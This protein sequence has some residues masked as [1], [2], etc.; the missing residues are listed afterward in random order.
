M[1]NNSDLDSR[2]LEEVFPEL[3][4][5]THPLGNRVLVQLRKVRSKSKGGVIIVEETKQAERYNEMVCRVVELGPLAYKNVDDLSDWKEGPWCLPGDFVRVAK[6]GGDRWSVPYGV[7]DDKDWVHFIVV[8]D[9]EI[10]A[11]IDSFEA[12]KAIAAFLE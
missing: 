8:Q 1:S 10:T 12:A 6:Y 11:R 5:T 2:T 9:R 3:Q 7:G 4:Q